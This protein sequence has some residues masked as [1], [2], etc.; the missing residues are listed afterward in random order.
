MTLAG[1]P[2]AVHRHGRV[3]TAAIDLRGRPAGTY[4][5]RIEARERGGRKVTG[6]RT[7]RTCATAG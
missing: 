6:T 1:R 4:T 3:S 2:V 7:Y 5:A